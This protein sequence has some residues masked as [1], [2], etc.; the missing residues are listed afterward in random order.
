MD[1]LGVGEDILQRVD[2]PCWNAPLL[3]CLQHFATGEFRQGFAQQRNQQRAILDS[4]PVCR[5]PGI[6]GEFHEPEVLAKASKLPIITHRKNH[7]PVAHGKH[8][9]WDDVG[10]SIPHP[11]WW[12][13]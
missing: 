9:I 4:A 6:G 3:H 12:S 13:T 5:E 11:V 2:G 1:Y 10:M 8:L 7:V